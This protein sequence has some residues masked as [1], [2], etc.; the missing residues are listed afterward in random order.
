MKTD[1]DLIFEAYNKT[2]NE[3]TAGEGAVN[4]L[5]QLKGEVPELEDKI[6]QILEKV[7]DAVDILKQE[8]YVNDP[9]LKQA[10]ESLI[11]GDF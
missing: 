9:Q 8:T 10:H 6:N 3:N 1:Q 7:F 2:L 4:L 5:E 11:E